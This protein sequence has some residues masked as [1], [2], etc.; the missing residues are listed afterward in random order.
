VGRCDHPPAITANDQ[1][2]VPRRPQVKRL[3]KQ[4]LIFEQN[5][6][7]TSLFLATKTEETCR[8][9]K[10]VVIAVAKVAKKNTSPIIDGQSKIY[11]RWRDNILLCEE[12]AGQEGSQ[13]TLIHGCTFD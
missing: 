10:E 11:R 13:V 12:I 7:A 5:I 4:L 8:K 1:P 6:A 9:T 2:P 3:Q